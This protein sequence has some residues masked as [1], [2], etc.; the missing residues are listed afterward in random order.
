MQKKRFVSINLKLNLIVVM[1]MVIIFGIQLW[2]SYKSQTALVEKMGEDRLLTM[3]D[4]YFDNLNTMMLTGTMSER[5]VVRDKLL[6]RDGVKA[7]RVLRSDAVSAVY[8]PGFPE[9]H[10]DSESDGR[11]L[12]GEMVVVLSEEGSERILTMTKPYR[13]EENFRGVNC[14]SCHQVAEG[15]VL[16]AIQITVSL[17]KADSA[18]YQALRQSTQFTALLMIAS[19]S[20]LVFLLNKTLVSRLQLIHRQID[21]GSSRGMVNFNL[22]EAGHDEISHLAQT[23]NQQAVRIRKSIRDLLFSSNE[24][25]E[26]SVNTSTFAKGIYAEQHQKQQLMGSVATILDTFYKR[27]QE[28]EEEVQH[29]AENAAALNYSLN[30][31]EQTLLVQHQTATDRS[32]QLA[33]T[34]TLVAQLNERSKGIMLVVE[35][36]DE[37][38]E[39]TTVISLNSAIKAARIGESGDDF[40]QLAG[41]IRTLAMQSRGVSREIAQM[42]NQLQEG[43]AGTSKQLEALL[44][45]DEQEQSAHASL[46][47]QMGDLLNRIEQ[48]VTHHLQTEQLIAQ[49][50]SAIEQLEVQMEEIT[51]CT[52]RSMK[53]VDQGVTISADLKQISKQLTQIIKQL[54]VGEANP[55]G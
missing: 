21:E 53:L 16:G 35:V 7:V 11:A 17:A 36:L 2:E 52:N 18:V 45:L 27:R 54:N 23:F 34:Q 19:L 33:T 14:L 22:T 4:S 5:R 48:V 44:R 15:T 30:S 47:A 49:G 9:E 31:L 50:S 12:S 8:G 20:I 3:V 24:L 46:T 40:S 6:A 13:A 37:M 29:V 10:V 26:N 41:E 38:T 42:I 43:F 25:Q 1:M 39:Q 28:M 51:Q 55:K 32:Q